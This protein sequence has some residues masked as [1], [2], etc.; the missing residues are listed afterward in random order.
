MEHVAPCLRA[1]GLFAVVHS[2]MAQHAP[3]NEIN[4]RGAHTPQCNASGVKGPPLM[5]LVYL[6]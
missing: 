1:N 5:S 2:D 3:L 4:R 6:F